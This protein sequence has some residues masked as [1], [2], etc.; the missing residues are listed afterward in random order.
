[1]SRPTSQEPHPSTFRLQKRLDELC[2]RRTRLLVPGNGEK[3]GTWFAEGLSPEGLR[4]LVIID[5]EEKGI[6]A[7]LSALHAERT[8]KHVRRPRP[9]QD[10]LH[11]PAIKAVNV[12]ELFSWAMA[13]VMGHIADMRNAKP[14]QAE[15][16]RRSAFLFSNFVRSAIAPMAEGFK[17]DE[18]NAGEAFNEAA[19]NLRKIAAGETNGAEF[20]LDDVSRLESKITTLLAGLGISMPN[21]ANATQS[22]RLAYQTGNDDAGTIRNAAVKFKLAAPPQIT[23]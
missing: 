11:P 10:T 7:E 20:V 3:S 6:I 2:A 4:E 12:Q 23:G 5:A 17:L 15:E 16:R 19:A 14:E 18:K 8:G 13:A 1:M 9:V 21:V 22:A